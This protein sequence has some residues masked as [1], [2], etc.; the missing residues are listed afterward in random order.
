MNKSMYGLA[1]TLMTKDKDTANNFVNKTR[2]GRIWINM[3]QESKPY[4]SIGGER[5]S[6]KSRVGG[7][8]ALERYQYE[9]AVVSDLQ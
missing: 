2:V 3:R 5:N 7:V 6:G 9:K 8:R 1:A 4:L